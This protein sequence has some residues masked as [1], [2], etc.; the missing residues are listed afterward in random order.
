MGWG[1]THHCPAHIARSG[2]LDRPFQAPYTR[3][4]LNDHGTAQVQ[5]TPKVD[6]GPAGPGRVR[7]RVARD[8]QRSREDP[9]HFVYAWI[10][11]T[12]FERFCLLCV[13]VRVCAHLL[14]EEERENRIGS[15]VNRE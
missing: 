1:R 11:E 13:C 2:H 6:L 7:A 12:F 10:A 14:E 15:W 8:A 5:F 3:V 9:H 4:G